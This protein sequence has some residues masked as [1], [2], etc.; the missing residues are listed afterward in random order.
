MVHFFYKSHERG[1]ISHATKVRLNKSNSLSL[2]AKIGNETTS[3][4]PCETITLDL[5]KL[6]NTL[7]LEPFLID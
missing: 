5:L 1:K 6:R 7:R 2:T 3:K 4:D